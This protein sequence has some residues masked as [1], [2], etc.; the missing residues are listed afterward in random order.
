MKFLIITGLSGAGK[1]QV[2]KVLEDLGFY[3]VDNMPPELLPKFAE[4]Y[5]RSTEP[6]VNAALVCDMRGGDLFGELS[7]GLEE[8]VEMGYEYE[9]L[10]L[11]A[12]DETLIKRYKETRRMH[13]L[14][15]GGRIIDGIKKERIL[16]KEAKAMATH[17]IDTSMLTNSQLKEHINTIYNSK[18]EF[19]G[20]VVNVMSFGFKYGIPLDADLVFDVRFLPNPFYIAELKEH[21]GLETC[22]H[23]Y[24]M[25]FE[26][27]DEFLKKLTDMVEYLMPH[28]IKEGKSQLVIAIGCTGGHHRSVTMAEE[29]YKFLNKSSH[30]AIVTHRDIEKG[31]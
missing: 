9:I 15:E 26:Q 17:I 30:H 8:L 25:N 24:V 23:D 3:C 6:L 10:F 5:H 4:I 22:V 12:S 2:I 21:T 28:Y 29:L 18:E 14:A 16:L 27:S 19:E 1:T 7:G 20:M 11:E 13:P 31:V